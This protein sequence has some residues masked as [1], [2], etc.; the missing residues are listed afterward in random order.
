MRKSEATLRNF[1]V[2][3]RRNWVPMWNSTY[4]RKH[5][6]QLL[7]GKVLMSAMEYNK[8]VIAKGQMMTRCQWERT[9]SREE[10]FLKISMGRLRA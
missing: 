1:S 9:G 3:W 5:R 10:T 7:N 6:H 2:A 8:L 4:L